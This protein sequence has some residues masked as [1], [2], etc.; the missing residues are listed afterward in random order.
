MPSNVRI[1][2]LDPG[3]R[4]TGWAVLDYQNYKFSFVAAGV[5][6]STDSLKLEERLLELYQG[7]IQIMDQY[8]PDEAAIEEVFVNKNP[9]STL[10][11][12]QARGIVLLVPT[13]KNVKVSTYTPNQIK[14]AVVGVGHA[15]KKQVDMMVHA[16]VPTVGRLKADA[17]DALAM[18]ICHSYM[19]TTNFRMNKITEM[20][21]K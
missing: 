1:I 21:S 12:G 9:Q 16:L 6:S 7:L 5:I 15:E 11:L 3:L 10:K 8:H 2:G 17:S 13:I 20:M 14:K 19:R 4:H 18:A